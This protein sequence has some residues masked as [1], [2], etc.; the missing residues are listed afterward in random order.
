MLFPLYSTL[1][2]EIRRENGKNINL[3]ETVMFS[4]EYKYQNVDEGR[5]E[6]SLKRS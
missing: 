4:E 1:Q 5:Q 2:N 3:L 6:L